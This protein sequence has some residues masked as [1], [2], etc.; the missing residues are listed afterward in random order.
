MTTLLLSVISQDSVIKYLLCL[1]HTQFG[2]C[3]LCFVSWLSRPMGMVLPCLL[4]LKLLLLHLLYSRHRCR[5]IYITIKLLI[6][7]LTRTCFYVISVMWWRLCTFSEL[8]PFGYVRIPRET[9]GIYCHF[10]AI[11]W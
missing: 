7:L 10:P 4:Y 5:P 1:C 8:Y 2:S 11:V 6:T 3:D 9:W